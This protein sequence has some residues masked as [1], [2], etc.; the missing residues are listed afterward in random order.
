MHQTLPPAVVYSSKFRQQ[1]AAALPLPVALSSVRC[2]SLSRV[3][4]S[5]ELTDSRQNTQQI[6]RQWLDRKKS[7]NVEPGVGKWVS[8]LN[9]ERK[10]DLFY[11]Q[12]KAPTPSILSPTPMMGFLRPTPLTPC[13]LRPR[14]AFLRPMVGA[15]PFLC[16]VTP[17]YAHLGSF[18]PTRLKIHRRVLHLRPVLHL[19]TETNQ[20]PLMRSP[21]PAK[22]ESPTTEEIS[23]SG[24]PDPPTTKEF[25]DVKSF[26]S[27]SS[28]TTY[29]F[30]F[31]FDFLELLKLILKLILYSLD[32]VIGE[33]SAATPHRQFPAGKLRG[34][35]V[36]SGKNQRRA[37][38][39]VESRFSPFL[40]VELLHLSYI[41]AT[42]L[43]TVL[44]WFK[45]RWVQADGKPEMV[46]KV[47]KG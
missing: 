39:V 47:S 18:T 19:S 44:G 6:S 20:D 24:E 22:S 34:V 10:L 8:Y 17:I 42:H 9:R 7:V 26:P 36:S 11:S 41:K 38:A 12:E 40:T 35:E 45:V 37:Q 1:R 29:N 5:L 16:P 33:K 28:S 3:A 21:S 27:S 32:G 14:R 25:T 15:G 30:H 46:S 31:D 23:V 4:L 43:R 2:I 13:F